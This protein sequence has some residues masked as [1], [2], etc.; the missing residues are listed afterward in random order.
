M[1]VGQSRKIFKLLAII[2]ATWAAVLAYGMVIGA[3]D[4]WRPW[5]VPSFTSSAHQDI[6]IDTLAELDGVLAAYDKVLVDVTADWCIECR[7]MERTL[8]TN[9]PREMDDYQVVKLDVSETT[10]NS[11]AILARYQ[12]FGPP[13]L[14]IYHQG[15][16]D[17]VL[18]GETKLNTLK[19]ALSR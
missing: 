4:A 7:I 1:S 10:E 13:A 18:L 6:K 2:P 11:R 16:L 14:L 8:F 12:L 3:N 15:K 9:R 17:Q 19:D 5:H